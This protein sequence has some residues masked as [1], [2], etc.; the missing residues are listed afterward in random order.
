MEIAEKAFAE[1]EWVEIVNTRLKGC[2]GYI[3]RRH[4]IED[5]FKVQITKDSK[6]NKV[7]PNVNVWISSKHLAVYQDVKNEDDLLSLIN[8]ALATN[9]KKWFLE[10]TAQLPEEL[11]F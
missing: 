2:T 5:D 3:I 8:L 10:L 7:V 4:L 1:G 11:P 6:G 9:D